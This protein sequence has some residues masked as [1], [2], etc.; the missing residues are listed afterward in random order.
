[1]SCAQACA[2]EGVVWLT[3][4]C[5]TGLQCAAALLLPVLPSHRRTV[6]P[7]E[8]VAHATKATTTKHACCCRRIAARCH[9][10]QAAP[11]V[12]TTTTKQH[13]HSPEKAGSLLEPYAPYASSSS[14][15][16][17]SSFTAEER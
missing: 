2:L 4:C 7:E 17:P 3:P 11:K 6:P 15:S 1:M 8:T 13:A 12:V 10:V 14:G 9:W 16:V 5:S